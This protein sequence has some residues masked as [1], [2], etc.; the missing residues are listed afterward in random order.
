MKAFIFLLITLFIISCS[1]SNNEEY[2][3]I[4]LNDT[5]PE[6]IDSPNELEGKTPEGIQQFLTGKWE[7]LDEEGRLVTLDFNGETVKIIGSKD[8]RR[9]EKATKVLIKDNGVIWLDFTFYKILK[10]DENE[11][12]IKDIDK[13]TPVKSVYRIYKEGYKNLKETYVDPRARIISR[14]F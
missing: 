14:S 3:T 13:H 1:S 9:N 2:W 5:L 10:A 12:V 4:R 6:T 7:Y 11:L 8:Y